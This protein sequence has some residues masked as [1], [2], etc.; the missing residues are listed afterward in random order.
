MHETL[1]EVAPALDPERPRYLMGVGTP[2]DLVR[3]S[4]P[5]STCSTASCR[6][7]TR[8]TGRRS[9]ARGRVVIKQARYADDPRPVDDDLHLRVLRRAATR[10]PTCA[11]STWPGEILVLRL[12]SLHN[13]HFYGELVRGARAAIAAALRVVRARLGRRRRRRRRR[14]EGRDVGHLP[15]ESAE[16]SPS[17]GGAPSTSSP[18]GVG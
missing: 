1:A 12:L 2:R 18:P 5:A 10:A 8:A 11:T 3:P 7:A 17:L 16:G 4:A 6:R 14:R 9:L 15:H 13:L